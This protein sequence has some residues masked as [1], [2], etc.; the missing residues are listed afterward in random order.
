MAVLPRARGF[1]ESENKLSIAIV[2]FLGLGTGRRIHLQP[3]NLV[4][5]GVSVEFGP[6]FIRHF[7]DGVGIEGDFFTGQPVNFVFRLADVCV[8]RLDLFMVLITRLFGDGLLLIGDDEG[9][10]YQRKHGAK[11]GGEFGFHPPTDKGNE[12]M[13]Q[14]SNSIEPI[15]CFYQA[16]DTNSLMRLVAPATNELQTRY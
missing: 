14:V 13:H 4:A 6:L 3:L 9:N 5:V 1:D 15:G 7:G 8:D 16:R 10:S 11:C 12:F 2:E